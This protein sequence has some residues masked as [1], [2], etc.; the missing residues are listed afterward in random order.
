MN[1]GQHHQQTR[2]RIHKNLEIYPHSDKWKNFIDKLVY[3]AGILSPLFTLPQVYKI[4][5][6]KSAY[7]ISL[8]TWII[9]LFVSITWLLYGISHKEKPIIV[10]NLGLT[11]VNLLVVIGAIIYGGIF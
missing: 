2:K 11:T 8:I 4:W 3:V 7:D 1:L 6:N 10:L 5:I 9:Y